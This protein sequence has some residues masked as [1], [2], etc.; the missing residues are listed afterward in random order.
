MFAKIIYGGLPTPL[1][2]TLVAI[3]QFYAIRAFA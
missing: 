3:A 1:L 2:Y